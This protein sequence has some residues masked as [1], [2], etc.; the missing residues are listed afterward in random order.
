MLTGPAHHLQ[1]LLLPRF[2]N[3]GRLDRVSPLYRFLA[4]V[5]AKTIYT[6]ENS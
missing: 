5:P 2:H 1:K 6:Y 4:S 3:K